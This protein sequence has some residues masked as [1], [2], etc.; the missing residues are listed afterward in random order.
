M[1]EVAEL[2]FNLMQR[3]LTVVHRPDGLDAIV[4]ALGTLGF[5]PE[6]AGATDDLGTSP[7]ASEIRKPWWPL[8]V[9][10]VAAVGS[11]AASWAG[12]PVWIVAALALLA[13]G[14]SGLGTYKKAGSPFGTATSISMR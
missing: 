9:A 5:K 10:G 11:E 8:A 13:V 7:D 3:V 1:A 14:C 12:S 6:L 4:K 2:Q